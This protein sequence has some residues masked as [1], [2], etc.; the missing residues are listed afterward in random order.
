[1]NNLFNCLK[2]KFYKR[3]ESPYLPCTPGKNNRTALVEGQEARI[4]VYIGRNKGKPE[5][6]TQYLK[7]GYSFSEE[8]KREIQE[9]QLRRAL[10]SH[11]PFFA[12][13]DFLDDK[14]ANLLKIN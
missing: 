6:L 4:E 9:R 14:F 10:L 3:V 2:K 12:T 1:M 5:L 13:M 11:N 7:R 8:R